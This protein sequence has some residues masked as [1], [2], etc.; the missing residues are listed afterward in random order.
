MKK[1]GIKWV[2]IGPV[3]NILVKMVDPIFAGICQDKNVL[4]GGKSII[5][6]Y[7]EERVG[8]FCKKDGKPD[9]IEYTEISKE[10]SEMK[11]EK[12]ELV[13]SESHINCNLFNI[14]IIYL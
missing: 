3:D 14:N 7:P 12:G 6:G 1:R 8:V 4:A 2:F 5:K 9:V 13:Y 11:N 10:M